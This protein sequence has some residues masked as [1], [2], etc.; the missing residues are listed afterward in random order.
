ME[1]MGFDPRH[2]IGYERAMGKIHVNRDRRNLGQ[3]TPEEIAEGLASGRFIPSDLAWREGMEAWQPLSTFTDLPQPAA[4]PPPEI[5][6]AAENV[7]P[8]LDSAAGFPWDRR[9]EIG[10]INALW[11]TLSQ[12][13]GQP[14]KLFA[15]LPETMTMGGPYRYYLLLA[16]VTGAINIGIML[17]FIKAA[18]ALVASSP[19]AANSAQVKAMMASFNN[20]SFGRMLFTLVVFIPVT[21]FVA[22][23]ACHGLLALFGGVKRSFLTTFAVVCYVLGSVSPLQLLLCCGAVV[24]FIWALVSLSSG[25][26]AAH[27]TETWRAA[28]AVTIVFLIYFMISV[29]GAMASMPALPAAGMAPR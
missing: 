2:G 10:F 17:I 14:S 28:M 15:R 4:E 16:L 23:A 20:V 29:L 9:G 27:R 8:P 5:P 19:E 22:A 1:S 11:E 6:I 7:P 18:V 24:Q 26:G 13:L 12:S 3:F 21:P 25:L